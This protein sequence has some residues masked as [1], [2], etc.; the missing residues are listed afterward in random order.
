[1]VVEDHPVFREGL[2]M[3]IAAEADMETVAQASTA[4]EALQEYRR[5]KPDVILM[6]QR[7]PGASGT[8]A[9]IAIRSEFPHAK[10]MMLTTSSGDIEIQRA[11]RAGAT[12][13]VLKSTPK[14]ELLRIIRTVSMGR[15]HI[16]SDVGSSLAEHMGQE[17][18]TP[19]ELEVLELIREGNKNKQIADQLGISET[20]V[21]FHIKNIV[22]KLQA[23]DRTHA[24]TIALRRGLLQ[25]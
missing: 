24:V 5:T 18:L 22:D 16:P 9:L 20:T 7:L 2:N 13:Y 17:D 19:R 25:I 15:K 10:I 14:N 3:I 23:N 12:A 11:L 8:E 21:N 1:M 4:E 6:D